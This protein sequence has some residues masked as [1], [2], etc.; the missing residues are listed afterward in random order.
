MSIGLFLY[1]HQSGLGFVFHLLVLAA[2]APA[3]TVLLFQPSLLLVVGLER[4]VHQ[5]ALYICGKLLT[6]GLWSLYDDL[7]QQGTL[8]LAVVL[9]VQA[10]A[11]SQGAKRCQAGHEGWEFAV[12]G[13]IAYH[14][15]DNRRQ[16]LVS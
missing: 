3:L 1:L 14:F 7:Q 5:Q 9:V 2:V 6:A 11:G 13:S 12:S 15:S 8:A 16:I 4:V 10:D